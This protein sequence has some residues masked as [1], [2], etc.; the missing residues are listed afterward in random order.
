MDAPRRPARAGAPAPRRALA[1]LR[2]ARRAP[3]L[4]ERA[5]RRPSPRTSPGPTSSSPPTPPCSS[6]RS[7]PR[8]CR[9]AP[10]PR[11]SGACYAANAFLE[12]PRV[13]SVDFRT[14]PGV[15]DLLEV[16]AETEPHVDAL[17]DDYL[18]N[19][20][21]AARL[22]ADAII[23]LATQPASVRSRG[24]PAGLDRGTGAGL[25]P[26]A[27]ARPHAA[28][29]LR[30]PPPP[31]DTRPSP[32]TRGNSAR[33]GLR[34]AAAVI[35]MVVSDEQLEAARAVAGHLPTRPSSSTP[36]RG[37]PRHSTR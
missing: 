22:T 30:S 15:E 29:R 31:H 11:R 34:S 6:R 20:G 25:G 23:S 5:A 17:R 2:P 3:P 7:A 19:I 8:G 10:A 28:L 13:P 37:S 12:D 4:R 1:A 21:D 24:G 27:P 33:C 18:A 14:S 9:S 32:M 35:F 16:A 26:A 36:T